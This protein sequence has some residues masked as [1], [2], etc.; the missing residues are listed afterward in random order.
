MSEADRLLLALV[1]ALDNAFISSWQLTA[2]W[3]GE[4]EEAREYLSTVKTTGVN[5]G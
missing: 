3:D 2:Y 4:L 1:N 5:D